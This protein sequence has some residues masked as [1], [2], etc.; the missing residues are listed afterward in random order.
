M[1]RRH[2]IPTHLNVE[3]KAILGLTVRQLTVLTVGLS[4]G[5]ALW[6][7]WPELAVGVRA[8][9]ALTCVLL[10]AALALLR[11]RGRGLEEWAFVALHYLA[12]P[13]SSTWRPRE[14]DPA[15]WRPARAAWE[16]LDP[17]LAWGPARSA[18]AALGAGAEREGVDP[19]QR[20]ELT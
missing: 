19:V 13:K 9:L 7:G 14:P 18:S 8:G 2:E 1:V 4:S 20:E 11:P 12:T 10:A 6:S 3:D 16:E 17:R 15:T 5:Y